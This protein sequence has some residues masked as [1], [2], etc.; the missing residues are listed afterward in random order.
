M[1]KNNTILYGIYKASDCTDLSDCQIALSQVKDLIS[2]NERNGLPVKKLYS[3]LLSLE[4][5]MAS[6]LKRA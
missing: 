5:K 1:S 6:L 2:V 3:R 4:K